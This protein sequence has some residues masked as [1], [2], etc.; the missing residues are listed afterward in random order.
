MKITNIPYQLIQT[1]RYWIG[2]ERKAQ[3]KAR[4]SAG[5]V[6]SRVKNS[7]SAQKLRKAK[8][9][10]ERRGLTLMAAK[11]TAA[12]IHQALI[13]A[14]SS[15]KSFPGLTRRSTAATRLERIS[16]ARIISLVA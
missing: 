15:E 6:L 16:R 3:T 5:R 12:M 9:S 8:N 7:L 13:R 14:V 4:W 11:K 1:Q 2:T 10:S